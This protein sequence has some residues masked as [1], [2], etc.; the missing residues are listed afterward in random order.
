MQQLSNK[1]IKKHQTNIKSAV[2][3]YGMALIMTLV[4]IVKALL[5]K[6]FF[7]YFSIN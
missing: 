4:Y 3:A 5:G 7:F 2:G 1:Q 6:N